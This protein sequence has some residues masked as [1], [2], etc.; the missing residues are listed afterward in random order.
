MESTIRLELVDRFR[1]GLS[2]AEAAAV[3]AATR[4]AGEAGAALFLVGGPVRDLLLGRRPSDIDIAVEGDLEDLAARLEVSTGLR[5]VRHG[6][7]ATST[8]RGEGFRIDL[9]RT[10]RERYPR[11][12]AL[13]EVEAASV[14][15]DLARR[16]FSVNAMALRLTQP[17]GELLDPHGGVADTGRRLVRVLHDRSFQDDA[18]R[19]LRACRYAARLGFDIEP[20]TAALIRRDLRFLDSVSGARLRRELILAFKE[21]SA[22]DAVARAHDLGILAAIHPLLAPEPS[23]FPAWRQAIAAEHL[24]P[25]E[26]LEICL[27][28]R[29]RDPGDVRVLSERLHLT[30]RLERVLADLVRLQEMSD[31]LEQPDLAVS[32]AVEALDGFLPAAI[33]AFALEAGGAAGERCLRYLRHW[34]RVRPALNGHDL[35]AMGVPRGPALGALLRDLRV[36]RLTGE[37]RSRADELELVRRKLPLTAPG[38]ESR[39]EGQD[40]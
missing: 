26:E 35:E 39:G 6:R 8:L 25:V 29:C 20:V 15:E 24:A 12:G 21:P 3:E 27:V 14:L 1:A 38:T 19:M 36:A 17:A 9:A 18:T 30:G 34:R 5:L 32:E 13:P 16:D 10:R 11:P 23:V 37:A 33:W 28:S 2:Q 40:R 31:K 7:F 4:A 22:V